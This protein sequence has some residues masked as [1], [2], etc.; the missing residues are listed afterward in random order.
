MCYGF[1]W[2]ISFKKLNDGLWFIHIIKWIDSIQSL[3][4]CCFL[5]KLS[6]F[7]YERILSSFLF[8]MKERNLSS[9]LLVVWVGWSNKWIDWMDAESDCHP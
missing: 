1:S 4:T 2:P 9:S 7:F 8:Y 6:S 3:T 5:N